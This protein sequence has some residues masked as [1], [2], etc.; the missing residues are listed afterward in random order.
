MPHKHTPTNAQILPTTLF[1]VEPAAQPPAPSCWKQLMPS[2]KQR[3]PRQSPAVDNP[4][5]LL[6]P[7]L[8]ASSKHI[9]RAKGNTHTNPTRCDVVHT[10]HKLCCCVESISNATSMHH[11][12]HLHQI[13]KLSHSNLNASPGTCIIIQ[14]NTESFSRLLLHQSESLD[15]D[16]LTSGSLCPQPTKQHSSLA[17]CSCPHMLKS[18]LHNHSPCHDPPTRQ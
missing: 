6:L 16:L 18:L 15:N 1:T 10:I 7:Q 13:T 9:Y 4:H 5:M 17:P 2:S 14:S 3:V 8:H 12:H 11:H